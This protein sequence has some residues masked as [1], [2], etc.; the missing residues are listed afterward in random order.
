M[1][2]YT[3]EKYCEWF[4]SEV[5]PDGFGPGGK[6]SIL[7]FD[8]HSSRWSYRGLMILYRNNVFPFFLASHTTAW[9]QPNDCGINAA[10][11]AV[12]GA[13][14]REWR[15]TNYSGSFKFTR[16]DFNV[17]LVSTY[18]EFVAKMT[19]ELA[20]EKG[21]AGNVVTRA[22]ERTGICPP[23]RNAL[24]WDKVIGQFKNYH[25]L[26]K[27]EPHLAS[28]IHSGDD[29]TDEITV[30]KKRRSHRSGSYVALTDQN[31]GN[32][33]ILDT[34]ILDA[35]M[36]RIATIGS[37]HEQ[38]KKIK[39]SAELDAHGRPVYATKCRDN[40]LGCDPSVG[41]RLEALK[42]AQEEKNQKREELED[43]RR[44]KEKKKED[45]A[46]KK[47]MHLLQ[48]VKAARKILSMSAKT[49]ISKNSPM[50]LLKRSHLVALLHPVDIKGLSKKELWDQYWDKINR[51]E[52]SVG[53]KLTKYFEHPN[54]STWN[55]LREGT[56][57]G[58]PRRSSRRRTSDH[59]FNVRFEKGKEEM[60]E[61]SRLRPLLHV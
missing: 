45:N 7:V 27:M 5:L 3:F 8:G 20:C 50:T 48:D 29:K 2:I 17:V 24:N 21:K 53:T 16:G 19:S 33:Y 25:K 1:H 61:E 55:E 32:E 22:F 28:H 36:D 59:T 58:I 34:Y 14:F 4:V 9:A 44:A 12:Y 10:L 43:R 23:N 47:Q 31:S 18:T 6:K 52:I 13:K 54:D 56:V 49:G 15:R 60:I 37:L 35:V 46:K 42:R 39:K 26:N 57:I 38:E 40:R 51:N 11:N 30:I 41:G